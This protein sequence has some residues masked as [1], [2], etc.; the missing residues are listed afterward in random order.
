MKTVL[1]FLL[2]TF[3]FSIPFWGQSLAQNKTAQKAA[4]TYLD[5]N[6]WFSQEV[7][8]DN[9]DSEINEQR[10]VEIQEKLQARGYDV[11]DIDGI[12]GDQTE[13]ALEKFQARNGLEITGKPDASTLSELGLSITDYNTSDQ[14]DAVLNSN[15]G[16]VPLDANVDTGVDTGI[17]GALIDTNNSPLDTDAGAATR[18]IPA[19]NAKENIRK[20]YK[21]YD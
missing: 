2:V 18:D 13:I 1:Y 5:N 12:W 11:S 14:I 19:V 6:T 7:T 16:D 17:G 20:N 9:Y 4:T 8:Q 15:L 3:V 21:R 10:I